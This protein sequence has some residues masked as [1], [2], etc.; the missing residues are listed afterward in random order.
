MAPN[1]FVHYVTLELPDI[2][3]NTS[4]LGIFKGLSGLEV[5]FDVLEYREGGNNDFVHRL[6]G[7]MTYPNLVLSWGIIA[8]DESL[9]KWFMAT[10]QQAQLQEI[11]LTLGARQADVSNDI[12]KFVF[13]DAFPVRWSGP[14]LHANAADP[15]TWGE[16]LE[17]AHSG[18]K[19]SP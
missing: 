12:R 4:F 15:E 6:P 13:T 7:R 11:K 1:P 17:I 9:L 18:L 16:T 5:N 8:N 2:S 14:V 10:H 19:L 3:Q